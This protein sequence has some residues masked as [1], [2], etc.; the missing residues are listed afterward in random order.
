MTDYVKSQ[1]EKTF[2]AWPF[3]D[4][5]LLDLNNLIIIR[6]YYVYKIKRVTDTTSVLRASRGPNRNRI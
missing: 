4:Y 3:T 5:V 1:Q 2:D 6:I